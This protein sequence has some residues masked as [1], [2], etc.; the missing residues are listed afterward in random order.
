MQLSTSDPN[1]VKTLAKSR[2][3]LVTDAWA[4]AINGVS[5]SVKNVKNHLESKGYQVNVLSPADGVQLPGHFLGF[6]LSIPLGKI[7]QRMTAFKPDH[8]LIAT[9]GPVGL[10]TRNYCV[11]VKK[12]FSTFYTTRWPEAISGQFKIPMEWIYNLLRWFHKHSS[13]VFV[14]SN[15]MKQLLHHKGFKKLHVKQEGVDLQRFKPLPD[16]D[17]IGIKEQFGLTKRKGPFFLFVGRLSP[18]KNLPDFLNA[19][20]P[21]TKLVVGPAVTKAAFDKLKSDYPSVVFLGPQNKHLPAL[22][23]IADVMVFPSQTETF[24]MVALEALACGTP[25]SAYN[26][27]GPSDFLTSFDKTGTLAT[28]K[29]ALIDNAIQLSRL[30]QQAPDSVKNACRQLAEDYSWHKVLTPLVEKLEQ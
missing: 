29:N 27:I 23:N 14:V 9:E 22:Y 12:A 6:P 4:P 3:L 28:S 26:V 2:V 11:K 19:T 24:G 17:L 30:K 7:K 1:T 20:L 18:E 10:A 5:T 25:V 13:H 15:G 8:V 21:G 16:K